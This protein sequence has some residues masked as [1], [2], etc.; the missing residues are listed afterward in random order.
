MGITGLRR[1][2]FARAEVEERH[3]ELSRLIGEI[4]GDARTGKDDQPDRQD[5]EELVVALE[6]RGLAVAVPVRLEGDLGNLA[7]VRP[8]GGD[9]LG[10]LG[11]YKYGNRLTSPSLV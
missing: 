11:L 10:A 8:A 4:A 7:A 5:I 1:L 6:R 2:R 9:L 3:A